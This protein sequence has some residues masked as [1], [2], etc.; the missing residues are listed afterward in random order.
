MYPSKEDFGKQIGGDIIEK[1]KTILLIDLLKRSSRGS[2]KLVLNILHGKHLESNLKVDK[3][4]SL[5][6]KYHVLD[7]AKK[8]KKN[9]LTKLSLELK[10]LIFLMLKSLS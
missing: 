6:E 9:I 4:K 3:I 10:K 7:T 8:T 5:Y 1:K 2:H